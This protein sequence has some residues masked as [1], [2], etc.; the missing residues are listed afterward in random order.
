MC[1]TVHGLPMAGPGHVQPSP[2]QNHGQPIASPGNS[3]CSLWPAQ[4]LANPAVGHPMP[5]TPSRPAHVKTKPRLAKPIAR[6]A[7][8]HTRQWPTKPMSNPCPANCQ[9]SPWQSHVPNRLWPVQPRSLPAS[10]AHGHYS[11]SPAHLLACA[12]HFH[13]SPSPA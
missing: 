7:N 1:Y 13:T 11:L 10:P 8:G 2:L 9:L 3:Q 12:A 5:W 6:P 4:T